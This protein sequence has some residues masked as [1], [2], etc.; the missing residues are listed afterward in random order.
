M[1]A[2]L[3]VAEQTRV[4]TSPPKFS[5]RVIVCSPR[6]RESAYSTVQDLHKDDTI[7]TVDMELDRA[8]FDNVEKDAWCPCLERSGTCKITGHYVMSARKEA[9]Y[10]KKHRDGVPTKRWSDDYHGTQI[11]AQGLGF[12]LYHTTDIEGMSAWQ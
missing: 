2:Y 3:A 10:V 12:Y 6:T 1:T 9:E 8:I 4:K 11:E 5:V 7:S